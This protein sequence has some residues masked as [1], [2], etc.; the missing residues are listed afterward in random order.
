MKRIMFLI[1]LL[2]SMSILAKA[3]SILPNARLDAVYSEQF[4]HNLKADSPKSLEYMNWCLDNSYAIVQIDIEKLKKMSFFKYFDPVNT[5]IVDN[6]E[7]ITEGSSNVYRY[8]FECQ[9]YRKMFCG[10][11]DL[12][13]VIVSYSVFDLGKDFNKYSDEN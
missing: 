3:Y 2:S 7:D 1:V 13:K 9:L 12:G 4:L 6:D 5:I 11:G 10:S 8:C